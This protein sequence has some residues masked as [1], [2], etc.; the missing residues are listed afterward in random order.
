M[1]Q[2]LVP[3]FILGVFGSAVAALV[4]TFV[5]YIALRRVFRRQVKEDSE[6]L[7]N[8][9]LFRVGALHGLILA[10]VFSAELQSFQS[11]SYEL[12]Q[13]AM[14]I[15][16]L[17]FDMERYDKD[18]TNNIQRDIQIYIKLVIED[19]W[20]SFAGGDVSL[21]T[22]PLWQSIYDRA[23]ELDGEGVF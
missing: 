23:I 8:S 5:P 22:W 16:H 4:L 19:E 10:L 2:L 6:S 13:E 11:L 21:A 9:V 1:E 3:A 14:K 18:D 12:R 15:G 7:A 20:T 17:Y